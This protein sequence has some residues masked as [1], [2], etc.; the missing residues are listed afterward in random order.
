MSISAL[1]NNV[2]G[3]L[4]SDTIGKANTLNSQFQSVFTVETPLTD[5]HSRPQL[6]PDIHDVHFTVPGIQKLLQS[7]DPSKACGPDML[8]PRVLKELAPAIAQP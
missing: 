6:F 5:D 2:T 1:K 4:T 3:E 8:P 7:L